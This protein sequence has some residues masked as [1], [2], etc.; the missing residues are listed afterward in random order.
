MA[1]LGRKSLTIA[2]AV[3]EDLYQTLNLKS[4]RNKTNRHGKPFQGNNNSPSSAG[5]VMTFVRCVRTPSYET[6]PPQAHL[7]TAMSTVAR[8]A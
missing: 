8:L 2:H 1:S 4:A 5:C 3:D 7:A 6:K